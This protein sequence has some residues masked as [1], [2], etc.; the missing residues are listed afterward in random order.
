MKY[1]ITIKDFIGVYL[2]SLLYQ[3]LINEKYLQN[4]G[5]SYALYPIVK[6]FHRGKEAVKLFITKNFEYFNTNPYLVSFIQGVAI[7]LIQDNN[8]KKLKKFKFDMM[9]PLAALGDAISWGVFR[10]FLIMLSTILV[11]FNYYAGILIF[12][13]I[14][15]LVLN[16]FFRFMGLIIGY[17]NGMNVIFKITDMDIQNKIA[18]IKKTGLIIWG[19]GILLLLKNKYKLIDFS[20]KSINFN[21]II[22]I[23]LMMFIA[24]FLYKLNKITIPIVIYIIYMILII[25]INI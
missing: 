3:N 10:S 9:G 2:R 22:I 23:F 24:I 5:F 20:F 15:N 6:K 11:F 13:I 4:F 16:V 8:D 1:K 14:F 19:T 12:F 18:I 7:R 17:K 25:L 21:N